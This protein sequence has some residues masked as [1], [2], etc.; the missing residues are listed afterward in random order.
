[1]VFEKILKKH[2]YVA[3]NLLES[4]TSRS[5]PTCAE[6]NDV[7][8]TLASGANG[9]VLAAE[10]AIG[11]NPI[12]SAKMIVKLVNVYEKDNE[13]NS[14]LYSNQPLSKLLEKITFDE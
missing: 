4:M 3:T 12:N 9:L 14:V 1:M 7:F 11:L 13:R 10:T 5:R 8:N 6:V 2:V